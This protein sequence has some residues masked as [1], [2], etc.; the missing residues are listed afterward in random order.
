MFG[1][2][3]KYEMK[4][5]FRTF[6]T[7]F[8]ILILVSFMSVVGNF[9]KI[10]ALLNVGMVAFSISVLPAF[11]VYLITII[12]RYNNN[13]YGD[14][15]YLMFTLPV[16]SWKI[17]LSKLIASI[18]WGIATII[19]V[20]IM[21]LNIGLSYGNLHGITIS[22]LIESFFLAMKMVDIKLLISTLGII[23]VSSINFIV[24]IYLS[25]SASN[26]SFIRKGNAA[27]AVVFFFILQYI[28][29]K[30]LELLNLQQAYM[31]G[32]YG[33]ISNTVSD[34]FF[35]MILIQ[36]VFIVITF[37]VTSYITSKRLHI[38]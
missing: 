24:L 23:V 38:R 7:M 20:S 8:I 26:L 12:Q 15:G 6:F 16:K 19:V 33:N 37:L 36:L 10:D 17:I 35:T 5:T 9:L 3:L 30:I 2:L 18:L 27:V 31:Y 14:E 32:A 25:I 29:T 22:Y 28:E 13:L 21:C 1:K 34:A 4:S 11:I